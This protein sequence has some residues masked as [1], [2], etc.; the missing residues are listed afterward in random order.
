MQKLFFNKNH[1]FQL[2]STK[3]DWSISLSLISI[4]LHISQQ[5]HHVY[6]W[7]INQLPPSI[8]T[9]LLLLTN[10]SNWRKFCFSVCFCLSFVFFVFVFWPIETTA[11]NLL[12]L[13]HS[14]SSKTTNQVT[15]SKEHMNHLDSLQIFGN[16]QENCYFQSSVTLVLY[17]WTIKEKKL[18]K[19]S[20]ILHKSEGLRFISS[21]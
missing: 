21:W 2:L 12:G 15:L 20:L 4:T 11:A 14:N 1:W 7:Q 19:N 10:S 5:F 8:K 13:I 18:W 6:C 9:F 16:P 3:N 17:I